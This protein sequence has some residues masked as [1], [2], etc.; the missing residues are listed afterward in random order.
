MAPTA[1]VS[2]VSSLQVMAQAAQTM[3]DA[4]REHG[5]APSPF[6]LALLDLMDQ[7]AKLQEFEDMMAKAQ[8]EAVSEE[9]KT[10]QQISLMTLSYCQKGL[11]EKQ[12]LALQKVCE[13][14]EQG[15]SLF[16]PQEA[17]AATE[18]LM[19]APEDPPPLPP[20]AETQAP[21]TPPGVWAVSPP[22]GL[23]PPPGLEDCAPLPAG[24][25][26]A[27]GLQIKKAAAKAGAPWRKAA[28]KK[29]AEKA[30][31]PQ[32]QAMEQCALN[33]DAYSEDEE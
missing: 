31:S 28:A 27:D 5:A 1:I 6:A 33:F 12:Q 8:Q 4:V 30:P 16:G 29:I 17:P 32:P 7:S 25:P 9:A 21:L 24:I 2:Q 26:H 15:A 19:P 22:P 10:W 3:L 14:S 18:A 13:F 11:V 20:A 23:A